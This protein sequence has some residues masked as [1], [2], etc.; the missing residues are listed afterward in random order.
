MFSIVWKTSRCI[1]MSRLQKSNWWLESYS[2]PGLF[3]CH[4]PEVKYLVRNQSFDR[5]EVA[6]MGSVKFVFLL[7]SGRD[8]TRT[9]HILGEAEQRSDAPERQMTCAQSCILRLLTHLAMLQGSIKNQRVSRLHR[10]CTDDWR[11]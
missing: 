5:F 9:G 4:K 2:C 10:R 6:E 1:K 11:S 3:S 7:S 8:Q